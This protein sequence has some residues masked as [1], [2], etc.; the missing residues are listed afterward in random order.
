MAD[1]V[2]CSDGFSYERSAI[3]DWLR[4]NNTSPMTRQP[5]ARH[6]HPNG[7]LRQ[8][9]AEQ[10]DYGGATVA[11]SETRATYVAPDGTETAAASAERDPG[12]VIKAARRLRGAV[13]RAAR[14]RW[15]FGV[16]WWLFLRC[17]VALVGA[18]AGGGGGGAALHQQIPPM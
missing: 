6:L 13:D 5:I 4:L 1:P 2:V 16:V 3:V 9:I 15:R 18:A 10:C 8:M 7:A 11:P 17:V 14:L 12:R